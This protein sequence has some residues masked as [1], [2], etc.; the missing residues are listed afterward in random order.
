[1][2]IVGKVLKYVVVALIVFVYAFFMLRICTSSDPE[3]MT[4]YVWTDAAVSAGGVV[5]MSDTTD[6]IDSNGYFKVS[7]AYSTP[8][9][10]LFQVTV[11]YNN[12]TI[13]A[14]CEKYGLDSIDGEPFIYMLE[15]AFGNVYTDYVYTTGSRNVYN[16]R[17]LV[18]SGIPS[19]AG[20]LT[21]KSYYVDDVTLSSPLSSLGV[22]SDSEKQ[23]QCDEKTLG[24]SSDRKTLYS[25][26]YYLIKDSE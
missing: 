16:Y 9:A 24:D 8:D 17:Q 3:E 20:T 6:T 10:S 21:L 13:K 26:V 14:V 22:Y 19:D 2:K 15:D 4:S 23:E 5:Y 11:R 18:F 1:M 12:S 7:A 25:P